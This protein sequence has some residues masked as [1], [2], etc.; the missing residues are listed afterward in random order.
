[1]FDD[2]PTSSTISL[3]GS[4]DSLS[5]R[6]ELERSPRL[7]WQPSH[8]SSSHFNSPRTPHHS[9]TGLGRRDPIFLGGFANNNLT[10]LDFDES[11]ELQDA[12]ARRIRILRSSCFPSHFGF[13][14]PTTPA[15]RPI[16]AAPS[17][18]FILPGFLPPSSF[19]HQFG[20]PHIED[21]APLPG[22]LLSIMHISDMKERY[23]G[24][25]DSKI[26]LKNTGVMETLRNIPAQAPTR[27]SRKRTS[28]SALPSSPNLPQNGGGVLMLDPSNVVTQM[29]YS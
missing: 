9:W 1:M 3:N 16:K 26:P 13:Q 5:L 12:F 6:N 28:P 23:L 8:S 14:S 2:E 19:P 10:N 24:I 18:F 17:L 25:P 4:K 15:L 11:R 27:R 20:P 7:G 29:I 22:G 21:G